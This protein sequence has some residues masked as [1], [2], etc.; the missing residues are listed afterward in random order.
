MSAGKKKKVLKL[1]LWYIGEEVF[2][3]YNIG[4]EKHGL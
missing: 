4:Q 3:V 2:N 1:S